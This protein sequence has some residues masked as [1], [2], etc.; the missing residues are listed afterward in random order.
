MVNE[1][2]LLYISHFLKES[3]KTQK[4]INSVDS[5]NADDWVLSIS[6]ATKND[7]CNHLN[8]IEQKKYLL[9]T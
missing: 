5:L 4:N 6:E 3:C 9:L 2:S 8:Y 7:L 1:G